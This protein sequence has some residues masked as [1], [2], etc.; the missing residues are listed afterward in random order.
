[1]IVSL[2]Y[3]GINLSARIQGVAMNGKIHFVCLLEKIFKD[4]VKTAH[5][6]GHSQL[7][8]LDK[9]DLFKRTPVVNEKQASVTGSTMK[10]S[11]YEK[12]N[13][14]LLQEE[15]ENVAEE[16]NDDA[17]VNTE[18]N[19]VNDNNRYIVVTTKEEKETL[20]YQ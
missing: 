17:D 6:V 10:Q 4:N 11:V 15:E 12:K 5:W 7:I 9:Y 3:T 20:E 8:P 2:R 18:E 14:V 1:M 16:T 19:K 13:P